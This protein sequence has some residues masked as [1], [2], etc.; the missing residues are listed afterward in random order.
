MY[1]IRSVKR[2]RKIY[3]LYILKLLI[4]KN[5]FHS[6][7]VSRETLKEKKFYCGKHTFSHTCQI[8]LENKLKIVYD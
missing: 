3:V 8:L 1:R 7:D 5:I 2:S 4:T 6:T